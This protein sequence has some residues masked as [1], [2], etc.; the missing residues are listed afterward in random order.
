M[1]VF[2]AASLTEVLGDI[3]R[4]WQAAGH[5]KLRTSFASSS[6]L[7]RQIEQG[8]PAAVF[9][10]ADEQWA[11]WLQTRNLLVPGTRR[12]LLT[13]ALVLVMPKASAHP[14]K[15]EQGM[16][17]TA[18]GAERPAG[19]RRHHPCPRRHLRQAGADKARSVGG[20]RAS[21]GERGQRAQRAAAGGAGGGAGWHRLRDGRGRQPQPRRRGGR[22]HRSRMTRSRIPLRSSKAVTRPNRG[23][24]WPSCRGHRP[25][26]PLRPGDSDCTEFRGRRQDREPTQSLSH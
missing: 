25:R 21:S 1:T 26:R 20:S 3:D 14:V 15:I 6:T 12:D 24:F 11:D 16:D 2:A 19:G 9:A 23:L 7:A 10:S 13:N 17:L 22:S 18:A 5:A 8:A 4:L